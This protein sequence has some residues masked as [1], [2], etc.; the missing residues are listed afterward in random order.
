MTVLIF[1]DRGW[2]VATAAWSAGA[3]GE[4]AVTICYQWGADGISLANGAIGNARC[5]LDMT[6]AEFINRLRRP[7]DGVVDLR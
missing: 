3:K 2:Q 7:A 1:N 4:K 6:M 5:E